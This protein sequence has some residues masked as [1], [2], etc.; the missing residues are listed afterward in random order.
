MSLSILLL[1]FFHA[2]YDFND[3]NPGSAVLIT[4]PDGATGVKIGELLESNGVIKSQKFFVDFYLSNQSA[5]AI[6]PGVHEVDR[7]ISTKLAVIQ[8]L[9]QKRISSSIT[10]KEGSTFSD[11]QIGRAHV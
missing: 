10:V 7:H 1:I 5:R 4:I 6:A 9:D 3:K 2:T 11:V 8:L